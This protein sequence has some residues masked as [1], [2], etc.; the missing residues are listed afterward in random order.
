MLPEHP[1]ARSCR[2]EACKTPALDGLWMYGVTVFRIVYTPHAVTMCGGH[3]HIRMDASIC[4]K[5]LLLAVQPLYAVLEMITLP[6]W[7]LVFPTKSFSTSYLYQ[8]PLELGVNRAAVKR[9]IC[10]GFRLKM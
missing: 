8:A 7:I 4:G 2:A 10:S 5:C 1:R 9:L 3:P 6:D